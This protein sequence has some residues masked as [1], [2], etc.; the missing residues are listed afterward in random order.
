[1]NEELVD[2]VS[3]IVSAVG[4]TDA[5]RHAALAADSVIPCLAVVYGSV[6]LAS[7]AVNFISNAPEVVSDELAK[8][9]AARAADHPLIEYSLAGNGNAENVIAISDLMKPDD[10]VAS[11]FYAHCH[12]GTGI[13]DELRV[14][15]PTL[16]GNTSA[17]IFCRAEPGFSEEEREYARLIGTVVAGCEAPSLEIEG[18]RAGRFTEARLRERGLTVREAEIFALLAQGLRSQRVAYQLGISVRTVE[19]HT[20]SVYRQLGVTSR[21][22][23]MALL[24]NESAELPLTS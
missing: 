16:L 7:G 6:E 3:V 18:L 14:P 22:E 13:R 23:A 24:I 5:V 21:S 4:S 9:L 1:M 11:E 12:G 15:I 2:V 19:K 8:R 20:Q 10:F 17:L